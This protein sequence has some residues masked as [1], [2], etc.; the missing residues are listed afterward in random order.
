MWSVS[1]VY[2]TAQLTA[3]LQS[4]RRWR[5]SSAPTSSR[6]WVCVFS[7]RPTGRGRWRCR[8]GDPS[9]AEAEGAWCAGSEGCR[10]QPHLTRRSPTCNVDPDNPVINTRSFGED[11]ADV[12]RIRGGVR[13]GRA[14]GAC[15]GHGQ[16]FSG[17]ADTHVDSHRS[18]PILNVDRKRLDQV[19]LLPISRAI[20]AGV[21]SI[22]IGH[23]AVLSR[24]ELVPVRPPDPGE[25]RTEPS[26]RKCR[27]TDDA[28]D[29][30][31][32]DGRGLLRHDL[33]STDWSSAMPWIWAHH[34]A[35]QRREAAIRAIEAGQDQILLS[36][37]SMPPL[38]R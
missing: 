28:G 2:E 7:T 25:N 30:L 35:F 37:M 8:G 21:K 1:N 36:R 33:N 19:E 26:H 31:E 18:L 3:H 15:A 10:D 34:R 38:P 27:R 4:A 12:S 14:I 6:A 22:M 24:S 20:E 32:E 11:P 13:A 29:N 9:L 16:A 17:H 5:C 23:L